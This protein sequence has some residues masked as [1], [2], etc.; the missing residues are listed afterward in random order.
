MLLTL[1]PAVVLAQRPLLLD[2]F[3]LIDG[4]GSALQVGKSLLVVGDT[5]YSVFDYGDDIEFSEVERLDLTGKYLLP[6]LFDAHTH[7][8]SDPSQRDRPE[9]VRERLTWLLKNGVTGVRDMSGDARLL[10]YLARQAEVDEISAPDI[11][12]AALFAGKR[13]FDRDRRVVQASVGYSSGEAP[14]MRA[15]GLNT[16]LKQ[17]IAEAK[18]T[19]ATG[20]KLYANLSRKQVGDITMEA[21]RQGLGVWAHASILPGVPS[22]LVEAGVEVLSHGMLLALEQL[23]KPVPGGRPGIDTALTDSSP[24][25]Q[26]LTA[27]MAKEGTVLDPSLTVNWG[28]YPQ[29]L[30]TNG[31]KATQIAYKAGVALVV[32]TDR[33]IPV[34]GDNTLPLIEE[35]EAMVRDVGIPVN[36]VIQMTTLNTATVLGLGDISGSVETGKKANLL[37][38]NQNPMKDIRNLGEVYLVIKN[39]KRVD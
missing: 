22:E 6:G 18:G 10:S 32:G 27:L 5:I 19:G 24:K 12:F 25:L 8:A 28:R 35:M 23:I 14:W 2:N 34:G 31:V 16:D 33:A 36:E 39:G 26:L 13:F 9:V 11:Y 38:V 4:T 15:I 29:A 1:V 30:Y 20:L 3:T 17:V 37:I 21:K 7:L